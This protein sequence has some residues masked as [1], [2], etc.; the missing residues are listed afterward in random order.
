MLINLTN[1]LTTP[2]LAFSVTIKQYLFN[3]IA[4]NNRQPNA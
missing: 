2:I 4:I 1:T 3:N